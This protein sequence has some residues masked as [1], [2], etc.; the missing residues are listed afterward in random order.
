MI[1]RITI[2]TDYGPH[3][4]VRIG[5]FEGVYEVRRT[6]ID[7]FVGLIRDTGGQMP[8]RAHGIDGWASFVFRR[9]A[10]EAVI[11]RKEVIG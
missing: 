10:V 7:E 4:L 9:D 5:E 6:S 2:K 1:K 3:D 8:W 11:K